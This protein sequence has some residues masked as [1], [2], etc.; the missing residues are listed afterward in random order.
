M[1]LLIC[2]IFLSTI[3]T[4]AKYGSCWKV[5]GTQN[6]ENTLLN[7]VD[8]KAVAIPSY[9]ALNLKDSNLPDFSGENL[10]VLINSCYTQHEVENCLL[11]MQY[12]HSDYSYYAYDIT[13]SAK[14]NY[15]KRLKNSTL[16]SGELNVE[17]RGDFDSYYYGPEFTTVDI[18]CK[19]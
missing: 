19:F 7:F 8:R 18:V 5:S 3:S 16:W 1:K 10:T 14:L 17:L 4:Q 11:S 2:L 6:R 9:K 15:L 12:Q 13:L